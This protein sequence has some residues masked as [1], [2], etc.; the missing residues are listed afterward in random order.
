MI[1]GTSN[2]KKKHPSLE[3]T[4]SAKALDIKNKLVCSENTET[5]TGAGVE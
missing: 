2:L 4:E 5:P 3:R 1:E